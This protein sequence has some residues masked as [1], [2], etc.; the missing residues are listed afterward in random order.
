MLTQSTTLNNE[1]YTSEKQRTVYPNP[2]TNKINIGNSIGDEEF[3]LTN[4]IGQNVYSG[5]NIQEQNLTYLQNGI[6]FLKITN[7]YKN[8]Q[9][10]KLLK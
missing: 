10:I 8:E 4:S 9:I 1:S 6:Y 3:V 7:S 2:F 5:T